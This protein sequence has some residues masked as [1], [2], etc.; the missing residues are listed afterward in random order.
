[1]NNLINET[2]Q[3]R[4]VIMVN[5]QTVSIPFTSKMLAEQHIG[6]LPQ[7]QQSIARVVTIT[8]NGQQILLG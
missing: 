2:E 8:E 6:N 3:V 1:M 7:D 5:G 4:Y